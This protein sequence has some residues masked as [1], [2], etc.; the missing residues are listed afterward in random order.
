MGGSQFSPGLRG[1]PVV[2][3]CCPSSVGPGP[4]LVPPWSSPHEKERLTVLPPRVCLRKSVG[5]NLPV[6]YCAPRIKLTN[7][8][9][10]EAQQRGCFSYSGSVLKGALLSLPFPPAGSSVFP[11]LSFGRGRQL[12]GLR[13]SVHRV[14]GQPICVFGA[15]SAS[16]FWG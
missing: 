12:I 7:F 16:L 11:P 14:F 9:F 6:A 3:L 10:F 8:S 13:G 1:G 4:C 5:R 2:V 15:L